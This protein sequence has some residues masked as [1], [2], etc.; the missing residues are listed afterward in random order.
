MRTPIPELRSKVSSTPLGKFEESFVVFT[1]PAD[2]ILE[3]MSAGMDRAVKVWVPTG[4]SPKSQ[5]YSRAGGQEG[6]VGAYCSH[7]GRRQFG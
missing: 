4:T 6:C 2:L 7:V 5:V 1:I 3:R